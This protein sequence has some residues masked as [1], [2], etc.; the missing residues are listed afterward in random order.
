MKKI[1]TVILLCLLLASLCACESRQL[2]QQDPQPVVGESVES[3]QP[4]EPEETQPSIPENAPAFYQTVQEVQGKQVFELSTAQDL[5]D[6]SDW[7]AQGNETENMVFVLQNYID[8]ENEPFTPIGS[9]GATFRGTFLGQGY[10]VSGLN[11]AEGRYGEAAGF[12]G[13]IGGN[14]FVDGL[15]VN[16][17]VTACQMAGGLVGFAG[18]NRGADGLSEIPVDVT[19]QNCSFT[20]TVYGLANDI[21]GFVGRTGGERVLISRCT[22]DA[23]VYGEESLGG[24]GGC[25]GDQTFVENCASFGDVIAD[26]RES[27]LAKTDFST[28]EWGTQSSEKEIYLRYIGGFA[29]MNIGTLTNCLSTG[30]VKTMEVAKTVGGFVGYESDQDVSCYY[31]MDYNAHWKAGYPVGDNASMTAQGL[32][33]NEI[34]KQENFDGWNFE[35]IWQMG[36]THPELRTDFLTS[37]QYLSSD[38]SSEEQP[39]QSDNITGDSSSSNGAGY[40]S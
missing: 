6:L 22:V 1:Q 23:D 11:V 32:Y 25:L 14:A 16:G 4:E 17:T 15:H 2:N 20:G 5:F 10:T 37:D 7:V 38:F 18:S 34:N 35:T 30:A 40:Q 26:S 19:I 24:F 3:V 29:G 33:Y 13:V 9:I 36:E 21:G 12:F 28:P 31:F 39:Q 8:L 27:L